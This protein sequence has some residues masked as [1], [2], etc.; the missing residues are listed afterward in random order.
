MKWLT[1]KGKIS[2]IQV[3]LC[4]ITGHSLVLGNVNT[5]HGNFH[6]KISGRS[7]K[8]MSSSDFKVY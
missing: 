6:S 4:Q 3:F 1:E 8:S 2:H 7:V 5:L